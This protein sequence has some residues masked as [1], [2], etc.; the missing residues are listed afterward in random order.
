MPKAFKSDTKRGLARNSSISLRI[1][2]VDTLK[3][4]ASFSVEDSF[5]LI[6]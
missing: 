4:I 1:V 6:R 5:T 2:M 3:T